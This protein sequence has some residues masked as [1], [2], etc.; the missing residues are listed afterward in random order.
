MQLS[1]QSLRTGDA[2]IDNQIDLTPH[3]PCRL[4]C[5]FRDWQVSCARR[6]DHDFAATAR[7]CLFALNSG[8]RHAQSARHGVMNRVRKALEQ[9]GRLFRRDARGETFLPMREELVEDVTHRGDRFARREDYLRE[10]TPTRAVE[11]NLCGGRL[12]GKRLQRSHQLPRRIG[13]A[14]FATLQL[15]E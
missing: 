7:T 8:T 9:R 4:D 1:G 10:T 6:D 13:Q 12:A 14:H 2:D 11:I 5:F 15:F 3:P